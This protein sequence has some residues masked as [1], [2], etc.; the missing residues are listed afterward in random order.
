MEAVGDLDGLGCT[1]TT[2]LCV[3]ASSIANDNLHTGMTPQPIGEDFGSPL[4]D[5]VDRAVR[6]EV[7]QE[8]AVPSLT[9][10]QGNIIDTQYTWGG[11]HLVLDGAQQPQQRIGTDRYASRTGEPR[12]TFASGLQR[13]RPEQIVGNDSAAR[14]SS[15]CTVEAFGE[16]LPWTRWLIA[17]P[18]TCVYVHPNDG[19]APGEVERTT[20]IPTVRPMTQRPAG[21]A[22]HSCA[23]RLGVKD[24]TAV[25]FDDDQDDAPPFRLCPTCRVHRDSPRRSR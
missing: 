9:S 18:P 20:L 19:A 3:C 2:T 12:S 21:W 15:E 14:I 25:A 13:K 5:Q 10:P 6:L 1:L 23:R 11:H 7:Y 24:K 16:D 4:I 17:E 8:R 22:R